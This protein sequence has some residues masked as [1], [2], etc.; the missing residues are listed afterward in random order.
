MPFRKIAVFLEEKRTRLIIL[1]A[2][3]ALYAILLAQ[4]IASP[5]WGILDDEPAL[6]GIAAKNWIN[7]SPL[8]FNFGMWLPKWVWGGNGYFLHHP[9]FIAFPLYFSY[10]F[11]G[12]GEWQTRLPAIVFSLLS[13]VAFWFLIELAFRNHFLT[14]V[15]SFFF[16]LFPT[17][18][19]FGRMTS[20]HVFASFF[21][22]LSFLL[23]LLIE[24]KKER[25]YV[26]FFLLSVVVGGFSDWTYFLGAFAAWLYI[27][28]KK[29]IAYRRT[30]FWLVPLAVVVSAAITAFQMLLLGGTAA[31]LEVVG[32]FANRTTQYQ[33]SLI[34]LILFRGE[35]EI[36]MFTGIG[37]V[38]ALAGAA[39][40]FRK[41]EHRLVAGVLLFPGAVYLLLIGGWSLAQNHPFWTFN[42]IPFIALAAAYALQRV[43]NVAFI[44]LIAVF[45]F[46]S[47]WLTYGLF[48]TRSFE[49][50]DYALFKKIDR[51][52]PV[53][54]IICS[55][56][57]NPT[58]A[59]SFIFNHEMEY[60]LCANSRYAVMRRWE[61]AIE[62]AKQVSYGLDKPF[63]SNAR[64][65]SP[66]VALAIEMIKLFPALK[67]RVTQ[68]IGDS[69]ADYREKIAM[70]AEEEYLRQQRGFREIECS[71]NFCFYRR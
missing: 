31:L 4:N 23:L 54:E 49:K 5:L 47:A 12:V 58:Y 27:I 1:F 13:L 46:E 17:S 63:V 61:P 50:D 67:A 30:L 48:N 66:E 6:F 38:L 16:V 64:K 9:Q 33:A 28:L 21:T 11:F 60:G 20:F 15:A 57:V 55:G 65:S 24:A 35:N 22:I 40:L 53:Q 52:V 14:L 62:Y 68:L 8:T 19:F 70:S 32:V 51:E 42:L 45:V 43:K 39:F 69:G 34:K 59:Q 71:T 36:R 26:W 56:K 44:A 7:H 29:D 41:K 2:L 25:K 37:L 10:L 3:V 18:V